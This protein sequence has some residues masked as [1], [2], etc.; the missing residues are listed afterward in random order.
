[1]KTVRTG[2]QTRPMEVAYTDGSGELPD[3]KLQALTG[4]TG[5]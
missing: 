5:D 1:M 3:A 2:L 4:F